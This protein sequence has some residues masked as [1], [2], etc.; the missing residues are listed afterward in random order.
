M[1]SSLIGI[2]KIYENDLKKFGP[3]HKG[4]GWK[5]KIDALKRY[6][7][8]SNLIKNKKLKCKVLDLGCGLSEFY[9]F[10]KKNN[11]N[12]KYLG[13]D[14]SEKM[15]EIS[16]KR[17]PKNQ[18]L[19]LDIL[20]D[21]NKI[22]M[23]DYIVINGIFTQKGNYSNKKMFQFLRDILTIVA[24]KAKLGIAFNVFSNI[25]DWK[26][27]GNFYL[28]LKIITDFISKKISKNF[29]INHHYGLHEYT[30]YIYKKV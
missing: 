2:K 15:I 3:I 25:V 7:V 6:E 30:I 28:D 22:P 18:Y 17:Y 12:V 5:R 8:M 27:K 9:R 19:L 26:N 11:F 23:V 16:K 14:I 21:E 4:V 20:V 1:K 24:K 13:V 29:I 10:L